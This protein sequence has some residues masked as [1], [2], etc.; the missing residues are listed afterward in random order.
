[1]VRRYNREHL[2]DNWD[3]GLN[4]GLNTNFFSIIFS[5]A[6]P[7]GWPNGEELGLDSVLLSRILLPGANNS[8]GL[9]KTHEVTMLHARETP[10]RGHVHPRD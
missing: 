9:G 3:F 2:L 7:W 4:A 5:L 1:M 10:C 8:M 6:T